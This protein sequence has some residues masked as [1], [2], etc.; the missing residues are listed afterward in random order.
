MQH[1]WGKVNHWA[2]V[3]RSKREPGSL[4][5]QRRTTRGRSN[6][7]NTEQGSKRK[8]ANDKDQQYKDINDQFKAITFKSISV[9]AVRPTQNEEVFVTLKVNL[10]RNDNC[11]T[12][13]KAK[14]DTGAQGN[15]LPIRLYQ[16]MYPQN[17]ASSGLHKSGSLENSTT[18][19]TTYGGT[20]IMQHGICKIPCEFQNQK[21]VAAFFVTKADGPVIIGL[22]TSLELDLVTLNCLVRKS[23]GSDNQPTQV[24]IKSIKNKADLISQYPKCFDGIGKLQ[25][26]YHITLDPSIPLWSTHRNAYH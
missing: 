23:S 18:V 26:Q 10:N 25:G 16:Q 22:P 11:S 2:R 5:Q 6:H 9:N 12:T 13:L 24:S 19:L 3:C 7:R 14:L 1:V 17:A 8:T 15:I 20:T 4:S 21:S